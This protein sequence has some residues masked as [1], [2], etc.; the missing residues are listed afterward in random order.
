MKF[1]TTLKR[2]ACV[3]RMR[4]NESYRYYKSRLYVKCINKISQ[5]HLPCLNSA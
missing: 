5:D 4:I 2:N 1:I 3:H